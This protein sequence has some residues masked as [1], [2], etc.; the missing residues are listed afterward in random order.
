MGFENPNWFMI[1]NFLK[2]INDVVSCQNSKPWFYSSILSPQSSLVPLI[3]YSAHQSLTLRLSQSLKLSVFFIHSTH[4]PQRPTLTRSNQQLS[5]I[6]PSPA[7]VSPPS[8]PRHRRLSQAEAEAEAEAE[9][10][11]NTPLVWT[12]SSSWPRCLCLLAGLVAV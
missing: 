7:S 6:I 9:A 12:S 11:S 5:S 4:S 3:S 8:W 2:G 10:A 1:N